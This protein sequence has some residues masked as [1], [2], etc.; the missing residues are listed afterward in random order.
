[1]RIEKPDGKRAFFEGESGDLHASSARRIEE[2][3][4]SRNHGPRQIEMAPSSLHLASRGEV[5]SGAPCE[6]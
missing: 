2:P 5:E 4:S 6:K 3:D 1:M